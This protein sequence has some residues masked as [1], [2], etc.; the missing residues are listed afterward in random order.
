MCKY[1]RYLQSQTY[2]RSEFQ[3]ECAY[4][5]C[6]CDTLKRNNKLKLVSYYVYLRKCYCRITYF[7]LKW[8]AVGMYCTICVL[9]L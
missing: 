6:R 4:I 7:V 2:S 3:F 8:H 9:N 5:V 1:N